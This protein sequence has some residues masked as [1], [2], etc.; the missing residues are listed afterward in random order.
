[1]KITK[2]RID[3]QV[4][5]LA[6]D[7]DLD[8]LKEQILHAAAGR[9]DFVTFTPVGH[10]EVTVLVT[11]STPVRFEVEEHAEDEV[12][13]WDENPPTIDLHDILD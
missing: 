4:F 10:G 11:A 12:S 5:Y 3:G 1:M 8:A 7:L 9:P 13:G 2:L 6:A